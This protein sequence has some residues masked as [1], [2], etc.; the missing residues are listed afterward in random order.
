M[1]LRMTTNLPTQ[2]V[3]AG[4]LAGAITT[5]IVVV[6]NTY[7]VPGRPIPPDLAA[8]FTTILSLLASYV[9]PPAGRDRVLGESDP[10]PQHGASTA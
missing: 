1:A 5:F 4:G 8:A 6:M 10:A 9:T 3:W 7:V 2:K